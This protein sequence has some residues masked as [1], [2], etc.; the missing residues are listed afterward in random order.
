[1]LEFKQLDQHDVISNPK[2]H[3][4]TTT[5][6]TSIIIIVIIVNIISINIIS[7]NMHRRSAVSAGVIVGV[8]NQC[9]C[10]TG[11]S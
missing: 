4:S 11:T 9:R 8:I 5:T 10:G 6:T 3:Q 7:V 2:Q 1:M